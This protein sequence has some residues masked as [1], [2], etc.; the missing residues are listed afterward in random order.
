MSPFPERRQIE[1]FAMSRLAGGVL[2]TGLYHLVR[3]Y[4]DPSD[5]VAVHLRAAVLQGVWDAG[6]RPGKI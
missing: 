5:G 2:P 4:G 3:P 1:T 6:M